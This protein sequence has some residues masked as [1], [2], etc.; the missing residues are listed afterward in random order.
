MYKDSYLNS[1]LNLIPS[2]KYTVI[3][4]TT[5][6]STDHDSRA[7]E[8]E[9]YH[10]D[11]TFQ[12]PIHMELKRDFAS[13]K[14]APNS[15]APVSSPPLFEKYQFFGPGI[16]MGLIVTIVL[17]SVLYVAISGISSLQVSYAAFNKEMGP[18]A[19]K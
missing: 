14:R 7:T 5:P 1:L 11:T 19:Q 17:L 4:T 16:F 10:I 3:Y 2:S 9:N 8:P 15:T 13:H 18:G 6:T 12:S